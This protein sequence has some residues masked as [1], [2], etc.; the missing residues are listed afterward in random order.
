MQTGRS[1]A[2]LMAVVLGLGAPCAA[3]AEVVTYADGSLN[4][5]TEKGVFAYLGI[6]YAAPPTGPNRWR[7]PQP[8]EKWRGVRDATRFAAS[9]PQPLM[10]EGISAFTPEYMTPPPTS[11]DCLYLNVWTPARSAG[12]R[13]PVLVWIHGGGIKYWS[14]SVPVYN[15]AALARKGVVVVTINFRLGAL[16]LMALPELTKES[17]VGASGDYAFMDMAAALR[18]VQANISAFGGDPSKVTVAGQSSGARAI[19]SLAASPL[20]KGLFSRII[21]E[22]GTGVGEQISLADAEKVGESFAQAHHASS[23]AELRALPVAA[24]VAPRPDRPAPPGPHFDFLPVVDGYV[25]PAGGGRVQDT[26]ILTGINADE[27]SPYGQPSLQALSAKIVRNFGVNSARIKTIYAARTDTEAGER[28]KEVGR[29]RGLAALYFWAKARFERSA[30]LCSCIIST[31][32]NRDTIRPSTA[33]SMRRKSPT[34]LA[35]WTRQ[36][37]RSHLRTGKSPKECHPIG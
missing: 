17:G 6:P 12:R 36:I 20:G 4:G 3:T 31:T 19:H 32:R 1:L 13:L 28:E 37:G 8:V 14:G 33:P 22:S 23:L 15:G 26:P 30:S 11:E 27:G 16:G 35:T 7:A 29:D 5:G 34:P 2:K 9:C 24:L 10:P 18:W 21:A 25:F